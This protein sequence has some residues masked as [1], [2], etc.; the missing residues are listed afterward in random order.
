MH[1]AAVYRRLAPGHGCCTV[2][3]VEQV[4]GVTYVVFWGVSDAS[5][6]RIWQWC[7]CLCAGSMLALHH[8]MCTCCRRVIVKGNV[9][10]C[11]HCHQLFM[12]MPCFH[13]LLCTV[14]CAAHAAV[15]GMLLVRPP[16]GGACIRHGA[17]QWLICSHDVVAA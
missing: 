13:Q 2:L 11:V 6:S 3:I 12:F 7:K 10:A 17:A 4:L 9:Q 16:H 8:G 5:P 15:S 1:V 14:S